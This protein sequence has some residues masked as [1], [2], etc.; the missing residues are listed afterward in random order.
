MTTK[1]ITLEEVI[2]QQHVRGFISYGQPR[3]GTQAQYYGLRNQYFFVEGVEN[4]VQGGISPINMPDPRRRKGFRAVGRSVEAPDLGSYTLRVSQKIAKLPRALGDLRGCLITT[5]LTTG[6]C[7]DP[8]SLNRG[9]KSYVY[10]LANGEVTDRSL[11]D[12]FTMEGDDALMAELGVTTAVQY[13]VGPLSLQEQAAAEVNA[14]VLDITYAPPNG[15]DGCGAGTNWI[16]AISRPI[17]GSPNFQAEV[18]YSVNGGASWTNVNITGLGAS[19]APTAVDVMGDY[20]VVLVNASNA[21][22]WTTIDPDTGIP[23]TT[24]TSVTAGFVAS[25]AP[26]DMVV[27]S[28]SEAIIVGDGGYIYRTTDPTAGVSVLTAGTVTTASLRRVH[29]TDEALLAVGASGA[30]LASLDGGASWYVP[31]AA[32]PSSGTYTAVAVKDA[33]HWWI[34]GGSGAAGAG[35]VWYTVNGGKSWVEH[36]T[37]VG[38]ASATEVQDIVFPTDHVGYVLYTVAGPEGRLA[39][40]LDAGDTWVTGAQR[41]LGTFPTFDRGNRIATPVSGAA[42]TDANYIAIGGLAGDGSEGVIYTARADIL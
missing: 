15:C 22:Y 9:Y 11:G 34:A 3:P 26:R 31:Q 21:L 14:E 25:A 28:P 27:L 33:D 1:R 40:T 35:R 5:H 13:G 41:V 24:W 29:G 20:L 4:P 17:G 42:Q 32:T 6:R 23:G 10:I 12:P 16:Y 39:T 36:S 38:V 7:K 19:V 2:T 8:S 30:I 18:I 37:A